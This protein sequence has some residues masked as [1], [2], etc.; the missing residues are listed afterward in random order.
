MGKGLPD[1]RRV[2]P[3]ILAADWSRM[4]EQVKTV[5]DAGARVIHVDVMDGH[6]VPLITMGPQMVQTL[7]EHVHDAGGW[8][9]AHL[10]IVRPEQQ[11]PPFADADADSLHIHSKATPHVHDP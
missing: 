9:D 7:S 11:V 10:M 4:W 1:G 6:I 5:M 2:A 3:S 8:L